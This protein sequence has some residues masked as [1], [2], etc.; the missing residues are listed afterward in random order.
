MV[1]RFIELK[2]IYL[3][4]FEIGM[5]P[6]LIGRLGYFVIYPDWGTKFNNLNRIN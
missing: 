5:L 2:F 6:I 3:L 4:I 1:F